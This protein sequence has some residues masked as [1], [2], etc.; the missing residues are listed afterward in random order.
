MGGMDLQVNMEQRDREI[1]D[2]MKSRWRDSITN[3]TL[4]LMFNVVSF[5]FL[6]IQYILP[7]IGGGLLYLGF[8]ELKEEDEIFKSGWY[9]SIINI[10]TILIN[11]V[12][13][14]TPLNVKFENNIMIGLV[15]ALFRL[16]FIF[17][18]RSE[19][20]RFF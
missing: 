10:F 15:F 18:F 7:I 4:G 19:I 14:A 1:A 9:F 20:K 8:K 6:G 17:E 5:D 11:L 16:S 13:V 3:I 12:F 2:K